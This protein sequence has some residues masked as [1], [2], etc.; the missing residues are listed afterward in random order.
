LIPLTRGQFTIVDE[1]NYAWLSKSL[2][3]AGQAIKSGPHY[4]TRKIYDP[5]TKKQSAL[6]MQNLVL[7][8]KPEGGLTGDHVDPLRTLDNRRSNLRIANRS[9]QQHNKRR[10]RNNTSGYKGVTWN[11]QINSYIACIKTNGRGRKIMQSKNPAACAEAYRIAAEKEHGE[12]SR[13]E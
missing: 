11:T 2:W 4:A 8:I 5:I 6:P 1:E 3:A 12:F 13:S 9:Q 10:S 7:G